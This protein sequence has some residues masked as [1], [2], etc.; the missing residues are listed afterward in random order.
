MNIFKFLPEGWEKDNFTGN[1]NI[2]QGMVEN[3]TKIIIYILK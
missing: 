3:V 2:F 1:R